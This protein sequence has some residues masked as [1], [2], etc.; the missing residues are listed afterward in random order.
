L[1]FVPDPLHYFFTYFPL[2]LCLSDMAELKFKGNPIHTVGNLPKPGDK[3][4]ELKL[5][6]DDLSDVTLGDFSG[7]KK[8]LNIFPSIDTPVCASS[9]RKFNEKAAGKPNA[10]VLCISADLPFAQKRFCGA[11]GIKNVVNLSTFRETGFGKT[12]GVTMQDGPLAG[13][14]ARAVIVLDESDKVIHTELVDDI[15]HEPNYDS[16]LSVI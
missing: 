7:K 11:E 16:A 4:P 12:Y 1:I 5:T 14:L 6:K 15:T 8:I 9:V 2:G 10:V 3:A 13:L